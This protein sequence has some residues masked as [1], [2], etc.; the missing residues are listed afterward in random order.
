MLITTKDV[1]VSGGGKKTYSI[2]IDSL[3][4]GHRMRAYDIRLRCEDGNFVRGGSP[5]DHEPEV[6]SQIIKEVK[7][8]PS[9]LDTEIKASG[10]EL[11]QLERTMWGERRNSMSGTGTQLDHAI[12]VPLVP[13]TGGKVQDEYKRPRTE[14]LN[15]ETI[16]VELSLEDFSTDDIDSFSGQIEIHAVD[17]EAVKGEYEALKGGLIIKSESA[18]TQDTLVVAQKE[19]VLMLLNNRSG[20]STVDISNNG[21][22][23]FKKETPLSLDRLGWRHHRYDHTES[24]SFSNMGDPMMLNVP[25]RVD[26]SDTTVN[27]TRLFDGRNRRDFVGRIEFSFTGRAEMGYLMV[28]WKKPRASKRSDQMA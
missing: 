9:K 2:T 23:L 25:K 22:E 21:R 24:R 13:H 12:E 5:V 10:H 26:S 6:I 7:C 14:D 3:P 17:L 8:A 11:T 4:P 28:A 19:L 1:S 20:F 16:S 18:I 27:F 15:N